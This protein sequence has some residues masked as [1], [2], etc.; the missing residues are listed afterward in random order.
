MVKPSDISKCS[1]RN[2]HIW[3][4][5]AEAL[6]MSEGLFDAVDPAVPI[7]SGVVQMRIWTAN[8][9][10]AYGILYLTLDQDVQ[11]KVNNAGVGRSGHLL[12]A[13]LAAFYTHSDAATRSS[14]MLSLELRENLED[15]VVALPPFMIQD[16]IMNSLSSVY[17]PITTVL[18]NEKPMRSVPDIISAINSWEQADLQ[19]TDSVVRAA[20]LASLHLI[21]P[22]FRPS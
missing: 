7:P 4:P 2:Y 18:Q 22:C 21:V 9:S 17:S 12:W 13:Q 5:D 11:K 19:K 8:N 16:K 10:K 14:F 3:K 1:G 20:R 6:L 15:I